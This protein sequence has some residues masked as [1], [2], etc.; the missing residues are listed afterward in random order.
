MKNELVLI[1]QSISKRSIRSTQIHVNLDDAAAATGDCSRS[2]SARSLEDL[3]KKEKTTR[4][5]TPDRIC[6][7]LD[8]YMNYAGFM[9]AY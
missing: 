8:M 1:N 2:I 3:G 5:K 9:G 6:G 7:T 4:H